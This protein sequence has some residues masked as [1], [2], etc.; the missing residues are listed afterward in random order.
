MYVSIIH[1]QHL[2]QKPSWVTCNDPVLLSESLPP[3]PWH[4]VV[5]MFVGLCCAMA[6]HC[7][8]MH[9][10]ELWWCEGAGLV[11]MGVTYRCVSAFA[12]RLAGGSLS[13]WTYILYFN[14]FAIWFRLLVDSDIRN[15]WVGCI[16]VVNR[17]TVIK[18]LPLAHEYN[19][20]WTVDSICWVMSSKA[21]LKNPCVC[22]WVNNAWTMR[23]I[24][25]IN[26]N[27]DAR[28]SLLAKSIVKELTWRIK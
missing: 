3:W 24:R 12:S 28:T 1:N 8:F 25:M 15:W 6:F 19:L 7:R 27:L 2:C 13:N 9:L 26:S 11:W 20:F 23:Y 5:L 18:L 22:Q 10:Y 16:H 21:G 17:G 4:H 14:C